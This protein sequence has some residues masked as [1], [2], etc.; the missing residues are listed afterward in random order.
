MGQRVTV[1]AA[2]LLVFG[3]IIASIVIVRRRRQNS[4]AL[5]VTL[6]EMLVRNCAIEQQITSLLKPLEMLSALTANYVPLADGPDTVIDGKTPAEFNE[7]V[8]D[9]IREIE[10]AKLDISGRRFDAARERLHKAA[11]F[12]VVLRTEA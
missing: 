12:L 11:R 9:G 3:L 8:E 1:L 6:N 2:A 5:Q 4:H 10:A 7:A